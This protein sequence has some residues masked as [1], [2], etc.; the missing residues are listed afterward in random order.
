MAFQG[1]VVRVN[2]LP[3]GAAG[4]PEAVR[5]IGHRE[6]S[7]PEGQTREYYGLGQ[8]YKELRGDEQAITG[9]LLQDGQGLRKPRYCRLKFTV[10]D[11]TA[12]RL[13]KLEPAW[14]ERV[15][16]D[17]VERTFRGTL[18]QAQGVFVVH[19]NERGGRPFGNPHAHVLLSPR[20]LDGKTFWISKPRL[21]RLRDR[22]HREITCVLDRYDRRLTRGL[23]VGLERG[24]GRGEKGERD[25]W[26]FHPPLLAMAAQLGRDHPLAAAATLARAIPSLPARAG[27]DMQDAARDPEA[28]ARRFGFRI[29]GRFLPPPISRALRMAR[30]LSMFLP[31]ER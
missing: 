7:L 4:V 27:R 1:S 10:N 11:R 14:R 24:R 25:Q 17:A 5:Y 30:G 28:L 3:K 22:W 2:Y 21:L 12:E 20:L 31:R 18:R 26:G 8:P 16:R 15:L 23:E 9:R 6:E 13:S 29:V 19:E